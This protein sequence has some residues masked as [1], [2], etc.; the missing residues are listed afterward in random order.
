MIN[1]C[2]SVSH[3]D[4]RVILAGKFRKAHTEVWSWDD[5][6]MRYQATAGIQIQLSW[7]LVGKPRP[8]FLG[9]PGMG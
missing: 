3:A 7:R 2:P 8:N 6:V 1:H 5:P 4:Q 9:S